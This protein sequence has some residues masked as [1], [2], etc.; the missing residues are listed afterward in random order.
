MVMNWGAPLAGPGADPSMR[1]LPDAVGRARSLTSR[2]GVRRRR[3][4]AMLVPIDGASAGQ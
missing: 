3:L 4:A 1:L 2:D